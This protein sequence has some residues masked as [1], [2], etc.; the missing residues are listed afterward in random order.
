MHVTLI[1]FEP[2]ACRGQYIQSAGVFKDNNFIPQAG[3]KPTLNMLMTYP[4][5]LFLK[6][7][8]ERFIVAF[9]IQQKDKKQ[10]LEQK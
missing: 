1:I 2:A 7:E 9:I 6:P 3:I 5:E 4:A 8:R 10:L